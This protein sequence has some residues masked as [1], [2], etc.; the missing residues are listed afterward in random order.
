ML[1]NFNNIK[2]HLE[3]NSKFTTRVQKSK[4][5]LKL[6]VNVKLLRRS[7]SLFMDKDRI[8]FFCDSGEKSCFFSAAQRREIRAFWP[9]TRKQNFFANFTKYYAIKIFLF[10]KFLIGIVKYVT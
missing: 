2:I 7:L 10:C 4:E 9:L 3:T 1:T 6:H 8:K 5:W